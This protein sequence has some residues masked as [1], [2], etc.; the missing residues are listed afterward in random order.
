M[1]IIT[2]IL[3]TRLLL[4][5]KEL[6]DIFFQ[7]LIKIKVLVAAVFF[8]HHGYIDLTVLIPRQF[9]AELFVMLCQALYLLL[10]LATQDGTYRDKDFQHYTIHD[11]VSFRYEEQFCTLVSSNLTA[12]E[13]AE[14]Y[15]ERIADRFREM[16]LIINFGNE[17]SFRKQ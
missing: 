10:A 8:Q 1:F 14:Y 5:L 11:M 2:A 17:Q 9:V 7:P 12:K 16:M 4:P 6:H 3:S 15:D 13:I